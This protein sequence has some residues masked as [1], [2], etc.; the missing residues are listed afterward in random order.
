MYYYLAK[1]FLYISSIDV[2]YLIFGEIQFS[3]EFSGLKLK[4]KFDNF[5]NK[6]F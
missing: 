2:V 4:V 1:S 3:K 6:L 5:E